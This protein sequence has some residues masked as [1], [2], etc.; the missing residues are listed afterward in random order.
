MP[1]LARTWKKGLPPLPSSQ[2]TLIPAEARVLIL[3]PHLPL[4]C[5]GTLEV[6]S[7]PVPVPVPRAR[8]RLVSVATPTNELVATCEHLT[9]ADSS[10]SPLFTFLS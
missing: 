4:P 9:R 6:S 7:D 10:Y 2:D 8:L 3:V 1:E 5:G